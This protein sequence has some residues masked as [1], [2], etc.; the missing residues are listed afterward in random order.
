MSSRAHTLRLYRRL[1]QT[2]R[3]LDSEGPYPI[4]L[5]QRDLRV[6]LNKRVTES[7][8]ANRDLADPEAIRLAHLHAEETLRDAALLFNNV[9]T[10]QVRDRTDVSYFSLNSLPT[11]V[12]ARA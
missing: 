6:L 12:S 9:H 10:K 1:L 11:A 2:A 8:R 5:P 4:A 3:C 7:F